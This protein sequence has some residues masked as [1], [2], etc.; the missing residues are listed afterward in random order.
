MLRRIVATPQS[1]RMEWTDVLRDY[2]SSRTP[3]PS[4]QH[5]VSLAMLALHFGPDD[6]VQEV[7]H[8]CRLQLEASDLRRLRVALGDDD[9]RSCARDCWVG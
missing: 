6:L 9:G 7:A 1:L 8:A 5:D 2:L 4:S 3:A